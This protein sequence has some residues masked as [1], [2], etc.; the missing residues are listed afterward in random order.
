MQ[1]ANSIIEKIKI[2]IINPDLWYQL[3]ANVWQHALEDDQLHHCK[4]VRSIIRRCQ[5][6]GPC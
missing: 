1:V 2:K 4:V 3:D 5:N 6:L